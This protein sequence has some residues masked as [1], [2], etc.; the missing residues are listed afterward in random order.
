M[1]K[2]EILQI[3][4]SIKRQLNSG[5]LHDAFQALCQLSEQ[6]MAYE[7]TEKIKQCEQT[8]AYMLRYMSQGS[9]DPSRPDVY[10]GIVQQLRQLLDRLVRRLLSAETPTLYYNVMR[11]MN[12]RGED[13][14]AREVESYLA[15]EGL[16]AEE[17]DSLRERERQ[18][19]RLFDFIWVNFP[20]TVADAASLRRLLASEVSSEVKCLVTGALTLGL[21]EFYDSRR[22]SLLI[23]AYQN[24]DPQVSVRGLVGLLIG[25]FRYRNRRLDRETS[26]RLDLL[27]D[28]PQWSKDLTAAFGEL[29][30][31][32]DTE[33][34]TRQ[35]NDEVLPD[36]MKRGKDLADKFRSSGMTP[37][38][39]MENPEWGAV[40]DESG[41]GNKI[42]QF[43]EIQESGGDVYMATFSQLKQFPFFSEISNWFLPFTI[44]R[45]EFADIGSGPVIGM[46]G[47]A[48]YMC[49]SDKYS[50]MLSIGMM[51]E[52]QRN[53]MFGQLREHVDQVREAQQHSTDADGLSLRRSLIN[54]YVLD[55]YRFFKLFR[56]K[57]EFFNPFDG[58]FNLIRV[59]ALESDFTDTELLRAMAEI[60][61]KIGAWSD[62]LYI[63]RKLTDIIGP[64]Q[65]VYQKCGY[66]CERQGDW[67]QA[68]DFY[69]M[70]GSL[71]ASDT[72][73]LRRT[74]AMQRK[75]GDL[76][77]AIA[78]YGEL[79]RLLPDDASI[80][81]QAGY[82]YLEAEKYSEALNRFF[83]VDF[84][85]EDR[86]EHL[87]PLAWTQMVSGDRK[88]ARA[89]YGRVLLAGA[90]MHDYV[91][92]G[93]LEWAERNIGDAINYYLLAIE[94]AKGDVGKVIDDIRADA[95]ALEKMGVDTAEMPLMIDA[96][97]Y[98]RF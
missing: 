28:E 2:K 6:S 71:S 61:F 17:P 9:D 83:K 82:T 30:R 59:K 47:N 4:N 74:A 44:N 93:H 34:L 55:L 38:E 58:T 94:Q 70:A 56:R 7:I 16:P 48:P 69:V 78:S 85:R 63:F 96:L 3:S 11:T 62:A 72:W 27:R 68:L 92:M 21:L 52:V 20:L 77:G 97:L 51:P 24:A 73:T 60:Y 91:N 25:L 65:D 64:R 19:R 22:F 39:A 31:T 81:M 53:A 88:G 66:C 75:L 14:V 54:A 79:E 80:A 87:R 36:L 84:L 26:D 76:T 15:L 23:D 41:L 37:E 13:S 35:L 90:D 5:M 95:A 18:Q 45:S 50:M 1:N 67:R 43:S 42:R 89:T 98:A 46:L 57:G 33:R 29:A 32:R 40:L 10:L 49:D 8:Y 12:M 86:S